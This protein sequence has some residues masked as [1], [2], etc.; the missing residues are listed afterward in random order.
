MPLGDGKITLELLYDEILKTKAEISNKIDA[1]E[2]RILIAVEETKHRVNELEKEN[3]ALKEEIETLRR[4]NR[5]NGIIVFGLEREKEISAVKISEKINLLLG[6]GVR[7]EDLDEFYYLG[8]ENHSPLKITFVCNWKK[9]EVL[10]NCKKL[11]GSKVSITNEQ[12]P[13]ELEEYKILKKHLIRAQE[14][15]NNKCF[16]K[17]NKL[18]VNGQAY[19]ISE[20]E[21][22]NSSG[23]LYRTSNSAPGTPNPLHQHISQQ[24]LEHIDPGTDIESSKT[25]ATV[26]TPNSVNPEKRTITQQTSS[27]RGRTRSTTK[28]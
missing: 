26:E 24:I 1:T 19:E 28:K 18:F 2:T 14:D 20:L 9:A 16:I 22:V 8:K 11:K 10:K 17:N 13:Q 3:A 12:T 4:Q 21:Q 5:K 25:S 27:F 23:Y 6:V 7:P 15:K